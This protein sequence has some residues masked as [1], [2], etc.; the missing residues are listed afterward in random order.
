MER[1]PLP[2]ASALARYPRAARTLS[3]VSWII[4]AGAGVVTAFCPTDVVE[5]L[6]LRIGCST[7][8][9]GVGAAL[10]AAGVVM[11]RGAGKRAWLACG[12]NLLGLLLSAAY[13]H[14]LFKHYRAQG[15]L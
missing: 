10:G 12:A 2:Y 9:F 3:N 6:Y 5:A 13:Y 7:L 11:S 1:S 4:A 8:A 15:W 14:L